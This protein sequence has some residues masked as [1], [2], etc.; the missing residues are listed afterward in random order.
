MNESFII[1]Q[2]AE[3]REK[4]FNAVAPPIIQTSN[5][6]YPTVDEFVA[7]I[8]NEKNQHI[9]TRGNNPTVDMLCKKMAALEGAEDCLMVGSGAAAI[10]NAVVSQLKA[11]DHIVS[12][13]DPY[14]WA[15]HLFTKILARFDVQTT[16]VDGTKIENFENACTDK[17]KL[18]YLESPNTWTFELQDL[19]AVAAFAKCNGI[20]TVID[21]SYCTA[22]CQRPI[23]LGIDLVIY[24]ATKYYNGH[25][26]VVAG[27][28]LGSEEQMTKIFHN[29][30]MTF[31][32]ILAPQNA[33]LMLR[34]L[35][36]LPI[37][38]K[39]S[40]ET[41]QKVLEYLRSSAKIERIWYPFSDDNP[42][43][44]LARKQMKMPMGQFTISLK[45]KDIGSIKRFCES[46][47]NFLI[48]VSWG[49]HESLIMPKC[50]FVAA[51]DPRANMIRFYIGL[52][53][54][55]ALIDDID[56]SLRLV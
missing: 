41:T 43:L 33:W 56:R 18:I 31:G 28:I 2:L 17:T 30:Y 32:N 8:A 22:L 12:V 46:L 6:A 14:S 23:D 48:A 1:N 15:T 27:A 50:G 47:E 37:R 5:F 7:A 44:D 42:Q 9:Y 53:E 20:T 10:T 11:G 4:Y 24:S 16:F 29:E 34:S 35:R 38:I 49:G 40:S 21:N 39:Q 54:A 25:S 3:D 26:D 51:D 45:T 36:T 55:D 52:E 13:R 19:A